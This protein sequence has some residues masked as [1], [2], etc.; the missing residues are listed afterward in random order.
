MSR[1][2][3]FPAAIEL[4]SVE[5]IE[6]LALDYGFGDHGLRVTLSARNGA[7]P[8]SRPVEFGK[9]HD[10]QNFAHEV[11]HEAEGERVDRFSE[12]LAEANLVLRAAIE[13]MEGALPEDGP[14]YAVEG[15]RICRRTHGPYV[16]LCNF[17]VAITEEMVV[18]DGSGK[19][20]QCE[21]VLDGTREDGAS[22][23]TAH[24]PAEEFSSMA[25]VVQQWGSRARIR[26]GAGI[27]DLLREGIQALNPDPPRHRVFAHTGWREI[28]GV[29]RFLHAGGGLGADG[30]N[31]DVATRLPGKLGLVRLPDPPDG[32]ALQEAVHAS[33]DLIKQGGIDVMAP[34]LGVAYRAPLNEIEPFDAAIFAY[35]VSGIFK[36]SVTALPLGHFGPQFTD[37]RL[38]GSWLSTANALERQLFLAKDV[39]L[40]IDDF[41]PTGSPSRVAEEHAKADRILRAAAN[42]TARDRL[43]R[44][45][46][47]REGSVSRC[48]AISSGEEPPRG[49]SLNAR[50]LLVEMRRGDVTLEWLDPAQ[51]ALAQGTYAAAMAGYIRY[52]AEHFADLRTV[53][54]LLFHE[55]RAQLLA[56]SL[57]ARLPGTQAHL[58]VGWTI[59]L[60]FAVACG[61]ITQTE[62]DAIWARVLTALGA[63]AAQTQQEVADEH[64]AE[65]FLALLGSVL[66]QKRAY[67]T[68]PQGG[69]PE[70]AGRWGWE[71]MAVTINDAQHHPPSGKPVIGWVQG[72]DMY[73]DPEAA[74]AAVQ[75]L[76]HEQGG[77]VGVG[78]KTVWKRLKEKNLVETADEG[79]NL[80]TRPTFLPPGKRVLHLH[81][82]TLGHR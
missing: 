49:E 24:V 79:R 68:T 47:F 53:V 1:M 6:L 65:R 73:L 11:L 46:D 61:A 26:A 45:A 75:D 5:D 42:Q 52:I 32:A 9:P 57:H 28:E 44:E 35:G 20:G 36:T 22:L 81:A 25:W 59:F 18:D 56:T 76:A 16:P 63:R 51:R 34:L 70:E 64:A 54:P 21:L 30:N 82:S 31:P 14:Q 67:L 80:L 10:L 7:A 71:A 17:H 40:V 58:L 48:I 78:A 29:M 13:Q 60:R 37:R 12:L 39:P 77:S 74:Y 33:L 2:H 55:A 50:L 66:S 62:A 69:R 19:P 15:G 41:C 43:S 8:Y 4:P 27:R 72:H 38:P 3:P 23:G